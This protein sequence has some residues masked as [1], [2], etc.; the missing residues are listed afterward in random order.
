MAIRR[1]AKMGNPI[2]RM[3]SEEVPVDLINSS[4]VQTLIRDLVETMREYQGVGLAAPQVHENLRIFV[5]EVP[6]EVDLKIVV[7]PS[8]SILKKDTITTWEG[9]LSIPSIRGQVRRPS[10]VK[11]DGFDQYGNEIEFEAN[12]FLSAIVQHESD[13]LDGVLF[14]DRMDGF[15]SLSFVEE[16]VRYHHKNE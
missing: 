5:A 2:L 8:L 13:H 11:V 7:N 10:L 9:C 4:D 16:Y 1:T 6:K 15:K 14:L 3:R 12:N